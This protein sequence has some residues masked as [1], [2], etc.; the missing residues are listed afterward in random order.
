MIIHPS[1]NIIHPSFSSQSPVKAVDKVWRMHEIAFAA[2]VRVHEPVRM[3]VSNN[4]W[5][6][7]RFERKSLLPW[8]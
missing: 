6:K 4:Q 1:V 5:D 2:A 3:K 8:L 7:S